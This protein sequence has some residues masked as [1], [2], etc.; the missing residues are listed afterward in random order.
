LQQYSNRLFA[1]HNALYYSKSAFSPKYRFVFA[2][3][4]ALENSGLTNS[5][6][7]H[8]ISHT[9]PSSTMVLTRLLYTCSTISA[10][11]LCRLA[12][13]DGFSP[14]FPQHLLQGLQSAHLRQS[15]H[16]TILDMRPTGLDEAARITRGQKMSAFSSTA[17]ASMDF[18]QT[19]LERR[20]GV[21]ETSFLD[22]FMLPVLFA[23]LLITSNT[24]GAGML[25]LPDLAAGLGMGIATI[26]FMGLYVVNLVSGLL[27]AEVAIKQRESSGT[28]APSSFK[29]F[30]EANLDYSNAADITAIISIA[31]NA[32]V[33]AFETG[34]FGELGS[35]VLGFGDATSMS[36]VSA[37]I[38]ASLV[39]TQSAPNLSKLAS[40]LAVALFGSFAAIVLPGL[41]SLHDPLAV[42]MAPGQSA[43]VMGSVVHA[44]PIILM[45][46]IFQNI[47]PTVTRILDYDRTKIVTSLFLGSLIPCVMYIAWCMAVLGGGVD[48]SAVGINGPLF[49]IFSVVTIAGSN[50]GCAT[51]MAEEFETYLRPTKTG[52]EEAVTSQ[53]TSLGGRKNDVFSAPAVLIPAVLAV[54]LGHFFSEDLTELLKL[55]GAYGSPLLYGALPIM[56]AL[57]QRE[58]PASVPNL[59]PGGLLS[60]GMLG[61]AST[62]LIGSE[63]FGSLDHLAMSLS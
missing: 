19:A 12:T 27:I 56:M 2:T 29:A 50:L 60:L 6:F 26:V 5:C 8:T 22:E 1:N 43:D 42:F 36:I 45:S 62:A 13:T 9:K 59:V 53:E 16:F 32:L 51:S 52:K 11:F 30:A 15:Q 10:A 23:S 39:G 28:D 38:V 14:S 21:S 33:L 3:N 7:S 41:T 57:A 20:N 35:E 47:V 25:V 61:M 46:L 37:A 34:K 55:A 54:A 24:V 49:T 18:K 44:A 40:L 31:R 48:T 4:Y 17:E 58:K 63:I